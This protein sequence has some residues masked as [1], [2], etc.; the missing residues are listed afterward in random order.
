M[1]WHSSPTHYPTFLSVIIPRNSIYAQRTVERL[2]VTPDKAIAILDPNLPT[3]PMVAIAHPDFKATDKAIRSSYEA[4][5]SYAKDAQAR[6]DELLAKY[7]KEK[8]EQ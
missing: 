3:E 6:R 8:S 4:A 5:V 7:A 2:W 1:V